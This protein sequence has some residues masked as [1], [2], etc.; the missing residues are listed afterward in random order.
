MSVY[1]VSLAE[2]LAK[3]NPRV[4]S[5]NEWL[6]VFFDTRVFLT[7]TRCLRMLLKTPET[8]AFLECA[9]QTRACPILKR[10]FSP[11]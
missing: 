8:L 5:P 7:L 9:F 10:S 2:D 6:N 11:I 3:T 4:G 1:L